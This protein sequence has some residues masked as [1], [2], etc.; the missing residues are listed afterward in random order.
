M[1]R[2]QY[3]EIQRSHYDSLEKNVSAAA[4]E[5]FHRPIGKPA[6]ENPEFKQAI[7]DMVL[8]HNNKT[9]KNH[10]LNKFMKVE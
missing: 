8:E 6:V 2:N 7:D 4:S 9:W 1:N 3:R 10:M 5:H